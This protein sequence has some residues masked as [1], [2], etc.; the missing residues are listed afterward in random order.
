M[1]S[2]ETY[3]TIKDA[4]QRIYVLYQLD[5]LMSRGCSLMEVGVGISAVA[6]VAGGV[7]GRGG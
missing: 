3:Q 7:V 2:K 5:W 4:R 6:G 1:S